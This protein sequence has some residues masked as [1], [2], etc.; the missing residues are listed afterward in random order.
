MISTRRRIGIIS[1][2]FGALVDVPGF[3]CGG[4]DDA[5][6]CSRSR[7]QARKVAREARI[8]EVHTDPL[9]LNRRQDFDAVE[10]TA[11]PC[12]DHAWSITALGA[13]KHVLC[14]KP[15]ALDARQTAEMR[16]ATETSGR[17]GMVAHE[18][19]YAPFTD[20]RNN[21]PM[22]LR[23]LVRDSR[24]ASNKARRRHRISRTDYAAS[25]C[26]MPRAIRSR[27]DGPWC[28][29]SFARCT[30]MTTLLWNEFLMWKKEYVR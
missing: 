23:L 8:W 22:T 10:I 17:T 7:E 25:R 13:G 21:T 4:W 12:A 9:E 6:I 11:P 29:D 24:A 16:G 18:F 5:E 15:L 19:R 20:A 1:V 14:A 3:R 27:P 2:G 28:S 30:Q 26:W